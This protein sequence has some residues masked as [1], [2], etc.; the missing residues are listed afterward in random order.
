MLYVPGMAMIFASLYPTVII[1]VFVIVVTAFYNE[2]E[3]QY[4]FSSWTCSEPRAS[5]GVSL[6]FQTKTH[7]LR[8]QV[9]IM[10]LFMFYLCI[11]PL[12]I[13]SDLHSSSLGTNKSISVCLCVC[14]L[15]MLN[16]KSK[17]PNKLIVWKFFKSNQYTRRWH[18]QPGCRCRKECSAC[19][20]S[21]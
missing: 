14:V 16:F 15:W 13:G 1:V 9:D 2:P 17:H 19:V 20:R 7:P 12:Y 4:S 21:L 3:E 18:P 5:C 10:H 6:I 8:S 11:W